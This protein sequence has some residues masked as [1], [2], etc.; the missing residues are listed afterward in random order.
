MLNDIAT[1]AKFD[2]FPENAFRLGAYEAQ[3]TA[4]PRPISPGYLEWETLLTKAYDD[5]KAGVEPK[6]ALDQAAQQSDRLLKK[7][8]SLKK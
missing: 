2:A 3:N 1:D 6:K 7:Y 8:E 5:M 4:V